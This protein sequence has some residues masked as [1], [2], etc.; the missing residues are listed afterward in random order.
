[1]ERVAS[2]PGPIRLLLQ[3]DYERLSDFTQRLRSDLRSAGISVTV[4]RRGEDFDFNV[5]FALA[6]TS[7]SAIALD[8]EGILV[9]SV[10]DSGFRVRGVTE[11]AAQKLAKRLVALM[12]R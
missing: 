11:G 8:R 7:A 12:R 6:D 3:G 2:T 5:V 4:V 1:M 9:A 10:V